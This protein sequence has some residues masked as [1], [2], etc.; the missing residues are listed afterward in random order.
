MDSPAFPAIQDNPAHRVWPADLWSSKMDLVRD[1]GLLWAG[2]EAPD[3]KVTPVSTAN[4]DREANAAI[5]VLKANGAVKA[6]LEMAERE[7]IRARTEFLERKETLER[8]AWMECRDCPVRRGDRVRKVKPVKEDCQDLQDLLADCNWTISTRDREADPCP[9]LP[10]GPK[11]KRE[12]PA[13][14]EIEAPMEKRDTWVL[15][16][17]PASRECRDPKAI[18]A[19]WVQSV[20]RD[21]RDLLQSFPVSAE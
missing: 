19:L 8:R 12:V 10:G 6:K 21:H 18:S 2:L 13:T 5:L 17:T 7:G 11:E 4:R 14:K 20:H 1:T 15:K 9:A 3:L 16:A